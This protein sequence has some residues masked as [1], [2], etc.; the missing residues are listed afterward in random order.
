MDRPKENEATPDEAFDL[1]YIR[2]HDELF[3]EIFSNSMTRAIRVGDIDRV[4]QLTRDYWLG[5]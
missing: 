4:F 3:R 5:A 1:G 2:G